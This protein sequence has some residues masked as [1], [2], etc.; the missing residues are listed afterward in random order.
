[1]NSTPRVC[2]ILLNWNGW[3]D[4]IECLDALKECTYQHMEIVVV[5]NGSTNGSVSKIKAAY[6]SIAVVE[7]KENLGF[8][9]G[10]NLGIRY[11]LARDADYLWLLNNNTKPSTPDHS[12]KAFTIWRLD[13]CCEWRPNLVSLY[14]R[15]GLCYI[16]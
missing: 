8:A 13:Q 14:L 1:M 12:L 3:Q 10:C 6:P 2:C 7:S 4:T 11:G 15:C 16:L 9:K 5:D